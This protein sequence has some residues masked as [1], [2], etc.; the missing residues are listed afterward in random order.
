MNE[1]DRHEFLEILNTAS[2]YYGKPNL[3]ANLLNLYWNGLKQ[4]T[5]DQ[6]K[7]AIGK[8]MADSDRGR[9]MP[10]IADLM[11]HLKAQ[12]MTPEQV[13]AAA[14]LK[15]TKFGVLAS[16]HIT[17]WDLERQDAYHL[18][19]R[20][21]EVLQLTD[22]WEHRVNNDLL[23]DHELKIMGKYGVLLEPYVEGLLPVNYSENCKLLF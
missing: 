23:T 16:M 7:Y 3:D 5:I 13:I 10:K 1:Q 17:D 22:E 2:L 6:I 12:P 9:F 4:F 8:H 19:Q 18:K 14:R 15:R 21:E 11:L 20:A